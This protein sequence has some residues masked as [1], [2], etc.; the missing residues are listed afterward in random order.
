MFDTTSLSLAFPVTPA[1]PL[2][3]FNIAVFSV[4]EHSNQ[5]KS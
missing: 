4:A 1:T 2:V 5:K 3:Y